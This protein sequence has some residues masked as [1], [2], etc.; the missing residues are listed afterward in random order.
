MLKPI[1]GF[2]HGSLI[3]EHRIQ[4]LACRIDKLV[5]KSATVLDVGSGDGRIASVLQKRRPDLHVEG[6][7]IFIR[8]LTHISVRLFDGQKIPYGDQSVDVITFIDVLHH[9]VDPQRLLLEAARV[10]R[11]FIIIKDHFS[12]NSLDYMTL[13]LMDWIGNARHRVS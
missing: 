11:K 7:D 10:A 12:E 5:P 9:T 2:V 13:K 8:N 1:I 3:Y 4:V 6:L